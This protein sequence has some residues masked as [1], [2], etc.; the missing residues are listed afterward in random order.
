VRILIER[1]VS[2]IGQGNERVQHAGTTMEE[3]ILRIHQVSELIENVSSASNE[4]SVGIDQV[5]L[6]VTYGRGTQQNAALF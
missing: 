1:S 4:Q 5:N 6:E 2:L 3:I